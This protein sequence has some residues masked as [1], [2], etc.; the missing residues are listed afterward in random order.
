MRDLEARRARGLAQRPVRVRAQVGDE[1]D[2]DARLLEVEGGAIGAVV[3]RRDDH[4]L[5]DLDAILAAIA[6]RG[7]GEH[8][9]RAV[10][11]REHQ[12]ALD[13]A[14]RQHDLARAHLP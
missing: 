3:R 5:A 2:V 8:H 13:R 11:I 12:R 4:A 1:R 10:V 7:L 6:P 9:A 14:G